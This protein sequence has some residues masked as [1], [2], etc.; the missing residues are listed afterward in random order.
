MPSSRCL[1]TI[2]R[3]ERKKNLI[4][5]LINETFTPRLRLRR[6][7]VL[8]TRLDTVRNA[9]QNITQLVT[10]LTDN[11]LP[12]DR[13]GIEEQTRGNARER[14]NEAKTKTNIYIFIYNNR[15]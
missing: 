2:K 15:R 14:T 4:D 7:R 1:N 6:C 10:S 13:Q 5:S 3:G 9:A 8:D 11:L 12:I